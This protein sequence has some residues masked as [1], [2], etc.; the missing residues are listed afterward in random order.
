MSAVF[1]K[2][3]QKLYGAWEEKFAGS[4]A[5]AIL[6]GVTE[7]EEDIGYSKSYA[8]YTW[9]FGIE[10]QDTATIFT[11]SNVTIITSRSFYGELKGFAGEVKIEGFDTVRVKVVKF[12]AK[13]DVEGLLK[14]ALGDVGKDGNGK[15]G[16]LEKDV[17]KH[18]GDLADVFVKHIGGLETVNITSG[19]GQVL[20][21]KDKEERDKMKLAAVLSAEVMRVVVI[22]K[23]QASIDKP[24]NHQM[25]SEAAEDVI[26]DP[27]KV[28]SKRLKALNAE[29]CDAC[30]SPII[31][32]GDKESGRKFDLRPSAQSD[33]KRLKY[34]CIIAS[35][36]GRYGYYCSNISRTFL[37][38]PTKE[39]EKNYNAVLEAQAA[40]IKALKPGATMK[41][42][43]NVAVK[44]LEK[45]GLAEHLTRN[46]GFV[47]GI[48]FR[49]STMTLSS[50][51]ESK[52][53]AGMAFNVSVGLQNL[54]DATNGSYAIQVADTVLLPASEADSSEEPVILT[55]F[56]KSDYKQISF[57][58]KE[59][60]DEEEEEKESGRKNKRS[61]REREPIDLDGVAAERTRG[62]TRGKS[63]KAM[64]EANPTAEEEE[65]RRKH[66]DELAKKLQE[67]GLARFAKMQGAGSDDEGDGTDV[68]KKELDEYTAYSTV[69]SFPMM[70]PR[71]ITV[72]LQAEAVVVPIN[73]VPVPFHISTIKNASKSDEGSHTYLRINFHMPVAASQNRRFVSPRANENAPK[74]PE[75]LDSSTKYVKELSFRST[76]PVNISDCVRKIREL[77][78]RLTVRETAAR[79]Q[80]SLVEQQSLKTV[81]RDRVIYLTDVS[82]RPPLATGKHNKGTLEAH[83]NG[84]RY[85]GVRN[86]SIDIIYSNIRHAFFQEARNEVIVLIH[87]HL[88][89]EIMVG[90]KKTKDVQF[91]KEVMESTVKLSMKRRRQFDQDELEEEQHER[92]LRNRSNKTFLR[93]TQEVESRYGVD[94]EAPYP[95]LGFTGA[96]KASTLTLYPTESCI[97]H[98]VEWPPFVLNLTDVEI[99][100]FERVSFSLRNFD[101]VFVYK[102]FDG[103]LT[104]NYKSEKDM[105]TRI[106]SIPVQELNILKSILDEQDIKYFEG[107]ANLVWNNTLKVIRDDLEGFWNGGGWNFLDPSERGP[108]EGG[109]DESDEDSLEGD[110]EFAPPSGSEAEVSDEYSEDDD[111]A[112]SDASEAANELDVDSGE[113]E[114]ELS[115][116]EEGMDWEDLEK[117][118]AAE[119]RKKTREDVDEPS[120]RSKPSRGSKRR[121]A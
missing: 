83:S 50:K 61:K 11:K 36:G 32:S 93:F 67:R 10:A 107:S 103:K 19:S 118:A 52:V 68:R 69:S 28:P 21:P 33:E 85:R 58:L 115:S 88:K 53:Q 81:P 34:G 96:P 114:G 29:L 72:D 43:Y 42:V 30:Y 56:C 91:Y 97:V 101:L 108:E 63:S 40:V 38:D 27:K 66:Q 23:V 8:L 104:G 74:F 1:N 82:S 119:D 92:E 17:K 12:G 55:A 26:I 80:K 16:W 113:G 49:D 77:R 44:V 46:V 112:A 89:N 105:W 95:E 109:S 117:Q 35:L 9:L 3:L 87:F 71:Q 45:H 54:K 37:V 106:T 111:Y 64:S 65:K 76:N 94:F 39:Q 70:R 79:E 15:I 20:A 120:R 25:L 22:R 5:V 102:G 13:G 41:S 18:G 4:E 14:E 60:E 90:K 31:Q 2:R 6:T 57:S 62:R 99:A 47:T 84:F 51:T 98:L 24:V 75:H 100:H 110:Q 7:A 59:D 86:G 121:R 116:D 73:G 48:E 78:K